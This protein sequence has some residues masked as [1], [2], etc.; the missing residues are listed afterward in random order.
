MAAPDSNISGRYST[1]GRSCITVKI[2]VKETEAMEAERQH[3][4]DMKIK[5]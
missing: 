2:I 3:R 4:T 5:K 1:T